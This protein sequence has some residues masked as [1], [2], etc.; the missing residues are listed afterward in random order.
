MPKGTLKNPS[1]HG[2]RPG[3]RGRRA[4]KVD[5]NYMLQKDARFAQ[6]TRVKKHRAEATTQGLARTWKHWVE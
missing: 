2:S 3:R 4:Q 5:K 1:E 6:V